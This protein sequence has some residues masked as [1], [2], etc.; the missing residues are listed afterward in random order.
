M[1]DREEGFFS[2]REDVRAVEGEGGEGKVLWERI[3][4]IEK[5]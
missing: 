2:E 5:S 4:K 1:G 3:E